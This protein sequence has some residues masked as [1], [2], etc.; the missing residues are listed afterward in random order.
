MSNAQSWVNYVLGLDAANALPQFGPGASIT[1]PSSDG[2]TFVN[3][4]ADPV[5]GGFVSLQRAEEKRAEAKALKR[6]FMTNWADNVLPHKF[7]IMAAHDDPNLALSD[8]DK[9]SVEKN[10]EFAGMFITHGHSWCP[11]AFV[12]KP[13]TGHRL[14]D[15]GP[16]IPGYGSFATNVTLEQAN[17]MIDS[18]FAEALEN[19][20]LQGGI[21]FG[22]KD[23]VV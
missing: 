6:P 15:Q 17:A 9:F 7:A 5:T 8:A 12:A 1:Y 19:E 16:T 11:Q 18:A 22:G 2:S 14:W 13:P 20:K 10:C 4:M 21:H 23:G 3:G